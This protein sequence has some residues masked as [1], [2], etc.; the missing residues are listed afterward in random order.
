MI[1][2]GDY[3]Y[4]TTGSFAWPDR[5]YQ[6]NGENSFADFWSDI[7]GDRLTSEFQIREGGMT[8]VWDWFGPAS[9]HECVL[10]DPK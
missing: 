8:L 3:T 2:T 6:F 1:G 5:V 9:E 7:P 4:Y 10:T